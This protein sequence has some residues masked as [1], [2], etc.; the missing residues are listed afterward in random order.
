MDAKGANVVKNV[1]V[2]SVI[3]YLYLYKRLELISFEMTTAQWQ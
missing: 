1:L 2:F 3:V